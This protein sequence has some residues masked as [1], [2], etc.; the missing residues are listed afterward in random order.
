VRPLASAERAALPVLARGAALR[1][2]L[3][4]LVDWSSTPEGALVKPKNPL[5][6]AGRLAFHR[7]VET[8]EGYGA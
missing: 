1:F 7:K 6:Y 3:T 8:A 4:R 5:E 2:F